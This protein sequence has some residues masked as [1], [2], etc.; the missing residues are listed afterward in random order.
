MGDKPEKLMKLQDFDLN[1]VMT[2]VL[3]GLLFFDSGLWMYYKSDSD[4]DNKQDA[5]FCQTSS[6][7]F[8]QFIER[9]T[10][11]LIDEESKSHDEALITIGLRYSLRFYYFQV[12]TA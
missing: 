5:A 9:V 7:D 10:T 11:S 4:F 8:E 3:P 2:H 6:E 1:K 12:T